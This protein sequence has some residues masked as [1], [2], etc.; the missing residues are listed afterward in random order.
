MKSN[1]FNY[2]L[3][4]V[5]VAAV[6]GLNTA[7]AATTSGAVSPKAS[8]DNMATATYKVAGV[9]QPEVESNK[10]TVNI[11][12][13]AN[14]SLVSAANTDANKDVTAKP[15][16]IT[17]FT[18]TLSNDGNVSD[19]YTIRTASEDNAD[20]ATAN[21]NYLLGAADIRYVI[22]KKGGGALTTAQTN[23][24]TAL[25]QTSTT[26]TIT[27]GGT[28]K[29]LPDLEAKLVYDASTP[30][31]Q[32]G[33]NI[34]V[35]TLTATSTFITTA[36]PAN[37]KLVN[38]NQTK[39]RLP[40]FKIEKTASCQASAACGS[41]DLNAATQEITYTI[42]VTNV[43]TGTAI[44][45]YSEA[46]TNFAVRDLLPLG[47]TLKGT[48]TNPQGTMVNSSAKGLDNRQIIDIT[49]ANLAVGA[50]LSISF[51]VVIDKTILSSAGTATNHATVYAKYNG[52]APNLTDPTLNDII[53]GTANTGDKTNVPAEATGQGGADT[54][55]AITFTNRAFTITV[56][57]T[58]EIP[59][60][61]GEIKYTHTVKNNGNASEGGANRPIEITITDPAP[62]TSN[63]L[64]VSVPYYKLAGGV[65]TPLTVVD[66]ATG[67]YKLPV[68]VMI[69]AGA[70]FEIGYTVTSDGTNADIINK[71]SEI[72]KVKLT[73]Q[74]NDAPIIAEATNTTKI[75]GLTLLKQAALDYTCNGVIDVSFRADLTTNT[76]KPGDCIL[77]KITATNTFTTLPLTEVTLSDLTSQ[78]R[79][80]AVYRGGATS[81]EGS[82]P[83]IVEPNTANERIATTIATLAA[84]ASG[85]L[86]FSIKIN[87]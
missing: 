19:T 61:G 3:L 10:V 43:S 51:T 70:S 9:A 35:G 8:I 22:Q 65:E 32:V 33:G 45:G 78:W 60:K 71:T 74:G 12:E 56:G 86:D 58:Q 20:I 83:V 31:V 52:D 24:L 30:D 21:P 16:G 40:V 28:I 85:S 50:E 39:V 23:A 82:T 84:G 59:V 72:V 64:E 15:G 44:P 75:Q 7:N 37:S 66:A 79:S 53:D 1:T 11:S 68:D 27:N 26:G 47:M 2:S 25:G 36:Q 13:T 76:A 46:A 41:F 81:A 49:G 67:K 80:K 17:T 87:P 73:P 6:L 77:Y 34:G 55:T 42:K 54:T 62:N 57:S 14:F 5:G 48:V 4:A 29:L 18:H 69:A 63:P 38:E